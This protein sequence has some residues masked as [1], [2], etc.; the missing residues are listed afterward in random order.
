MPKKETL[1]QK[2]RKSVN[3]KEELQKM[4][5][6]FPEPSVESY[7]HFAQKSSN[8]FFAGYPPTPKTLKPEE[9]REAMYKKLHLPYPP[10]GPVTFD[11][12]KPK[13]K[14]VIGDL[15]FKNVIESTIKASREIE[16]MG[17]DFGPEIKQVAFNKLIELASNGIIEKIN[18]DGKGIV[19]VQK[20]I[21]APY[22]PQKK[23]TISEAEMNRLKEKFVETMVRNQVDID[24]DPTIS[25]WNPKDEPVW[26]GKEYVK[27]SPFDP[28]YSVEY[29]DGR[30]MKTDSSE[31]AAM[32]SLYNKVKDAPFAK[33]LLET[34]NDKLTNR[35]L[36]A[37][38][39]LLTKKRITVSKK[40]T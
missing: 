39:A 12:E 18:K 25:Y 38:N 21:M 10:K 24:N 26:N 11:S 19:E 20:V 32:D 2:T 17:E 33:T 35:E 4:F 5:T 23:K 15:F 22:N 8:D 30:T 31:A 14:V 27:E 40:G 7:N 37:K 13:P 28:S 16:R 34:D 1:K 36:A 29:V 6:T 9:T 3:V